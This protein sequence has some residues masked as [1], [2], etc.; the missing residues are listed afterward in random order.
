MSNFM[1]KMLNMVGFG[2]EDEYEDDYGYEEE[3]VEPTAGVF[4]RMS[5]RRSSRVVK[6]HN[7]PNQLRVVVIQPESF[8]EAKDITNHLKDRRPIVVNIAAIDKQVAQKI[9][10][11]LSGA[12]YAL[13]GDIQKV[14][15]DIFLIVPSNVDIMGNE[16][17]QNTSRYYSEG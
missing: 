3:S 8:E 2:P 12:V 6:L 5:E 15:R 11:F 16:E 14:S 13:E 7:S 9:I 4:D 1:N 10:D 17:L